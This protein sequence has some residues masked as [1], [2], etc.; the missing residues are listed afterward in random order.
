MEGTLNLKKKRI[1]FDYFASSS[2]NIS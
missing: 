1:A 2:D